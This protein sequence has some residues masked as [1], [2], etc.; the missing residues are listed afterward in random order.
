MTN[1][2]KIRTKRAVFELAFGKYAECTKAELC[3]GNKIK[4]VCAVCIIARN[5][6]NVCILVFQVHETLV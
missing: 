4:N 1:G 5:S 6:N 3:F 2:A